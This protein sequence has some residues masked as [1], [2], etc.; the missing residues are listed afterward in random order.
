MSEAES[1]ASAKAVDVAIKQ[2]AR[3]AAAAPKGGRLPRRLT[4]DA[5]LVELRRLASIDLG[6]HLRFD[7]ATHE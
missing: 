2:T 3:N 4:L 7:Y 5:A 1:Y 6:N